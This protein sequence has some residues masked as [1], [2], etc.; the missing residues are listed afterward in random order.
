MADE[1]SGPVTEQKARERAGGRPEYKPTDEQRALVVDLV[2]KGTPKATI[3]AQLKL[4]PKTLRKHFAAELQAPRVERQGL[5]LEQ[6]A[7]SSSAP[8]GRPEFEPTY[9]QR[10]DVRLW[11]CADWS[12]DRIA[13]A[14]GI[15]RNTL[16]KHFV[17]ELENGVD[18][19]LTRAYR[20]TLREVEAGNMSAVDRLLKLR[21][22]LSPTEKLP[23]PDE[24]V[25]AEPEPG[26]K[27]KANRDAMTAHEGTTWG[28]ILKRPASVN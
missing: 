19:V 20:A 28:H 2:A 11:K 9:R 16:L 25:P 8:G 4:A 22:M 1:S 17:E 3:A 15:S 27:E 5:L 7:P 13:R 26:K 12:D 18:Q 10:E 23:T 14:L 6:A 24:A 21:G